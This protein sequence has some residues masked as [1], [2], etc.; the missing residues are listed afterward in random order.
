VRPVEKVLDRLQGVP[1]SNGF[2]KALCPVHDDREPSLS[3]AE[4][5]DGRALLRCFAGCEAEEVAAKLGLEMKDLFAQRN[6]SRNNS[7]GRRDLTSPP[8]NAATVQRCTLKDYSEAKGLPVEFLNRLGLVDRKC[9]CTTLH[10]MRR[11]SN[12]L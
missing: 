10:P 5:D 12:G 2:W 6:G 1:Q 8:N 9:P 11:F 7:S 4:G 3:V